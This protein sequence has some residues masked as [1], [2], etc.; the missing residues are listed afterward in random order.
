MDQ[1]KYFGLTLREW[2]PLLFG[3]LILL[4]IKLGLKIPSL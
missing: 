3:G 2:V 4:L 1:R